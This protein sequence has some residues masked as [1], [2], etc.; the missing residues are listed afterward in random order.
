M[1]AGCRPFGEVITAAVTPLQ[2]DGSLDCERFSA[3]CQ[4]LLQEG[5]DGL[6]VAG[7]TGEGPTLE[8]AEKLELFALA[9]EAVA[10]DGSVLAGIGSPS[11]S[12]AVRLAEQAAATGV[13]GLLVVVPYYNRPS[14]AGVARHFAEVSAATELPVMA[15]NIPR[16]TGIALDR[17]TLAALN[18]IDRVVAV[19]QSDS[20]LSLA[21]FIVEQTSLHLYMGNDEDLL[22]FLELGAAGGVFVF[23]HLVGSAVKEVFVR[24]RAGEVGAA[25]RLYR[26]LAPAIAAVEAAPNPVAVKAALELLG[27]GVGPTRL[28]LLAP[29]ERELDR[30]AQALTEAGLDVANPA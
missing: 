12:Q 2:S 7:T 30:I 27:R 29:T 24:F 28:P 16:R 4:E 6:V 26:R 21:R 23:T 20:D 8:D 22:A 17:E 1:S 25:T 10:A 3:L 14:G 9:R 18:E 19:K 15:Y 13:D 5:S 11:T